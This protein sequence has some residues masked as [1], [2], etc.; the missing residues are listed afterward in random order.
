MSTTPQEQVSHH[1]LGPVAVEGG[2]QLRERLG[3]GVDGERDDEREHGDAG[4]SQ[5]DG[6]DS[7]R[8]DSPDNQRGAGRLDHDAIPSGWTDVLP[9]ILRVDEA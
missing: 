5:S 3:E 6:T 1:R 4:P 7:E 9:S 2:H 8:E